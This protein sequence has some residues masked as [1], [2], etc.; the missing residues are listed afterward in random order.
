MLHGLFQNNVSI[1]NPDQQQ[2]LIRV[3]QKI[4]ETGPFYYLGDSSNGKWLVFLGSPVIGYY[5]AYTS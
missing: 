4:C 3:A 1:V 2:Q 5:T